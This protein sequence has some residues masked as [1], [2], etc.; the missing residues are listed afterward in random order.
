M[1]NFATDDIIIRRMRPNDV[2]ACA[3]IMAENAL[4]QRYGVTT[5]AALRRFSSADPEKDIVFIAETAGEVSGFCWFIEKGA[6]NRAGYIQLIGVAPDKQGHGIGEKM[7]AA[8]EEISFANKREMF[9]TVSDF[10]ISAQDFYHRMGYS[11]AGALPGFV[12]PDVT[13]LI[14]RKQVP[15]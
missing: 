12:L 6:F 9:L 8:A 15:L 14:Y 7:L 13:E 2:Q 11:Q 1:D 10:N 3:R 4:W 5:E